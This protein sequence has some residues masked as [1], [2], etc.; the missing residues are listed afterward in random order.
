ME[1]APLFKPMLADVSLALTNA[2][3]EGKVILYEGAQGAMLDV[4]LGTYPFATSSNT[5]TGESAGWLC[6]SLTGPFTMPTI[7]CG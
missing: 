2:H 6:A 1:L 4:D 7:R 5:I 3:R